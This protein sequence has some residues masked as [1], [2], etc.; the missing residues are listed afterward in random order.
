MFSKAE[1]LI[2]VFDIRFKNEKDDLR[3]YYDIV[4]K[5]FEHSPSA[6]VFILLHKTDYLNETQKKKVFEEK[7]QVIWDV[8]PKPE[9]LIEIYPTT[10][11]DE[12][13]NVAWGKIIQYIIPDIK[14][15][16]QSL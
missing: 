9:N 5:L 10:I 15:F 11:W 16:N 7:S 2:Y 13:L 8:T 6:K 12:T 14:F 1:F 4:E 3:V